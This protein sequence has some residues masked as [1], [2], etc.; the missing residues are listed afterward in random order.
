MAL[1]LR[2]VNFA[3]SCDKTDTLYEGVDIFIV[4]GKIEAIG[5]D[6]DVG[7]EQVIN[8]TDMICYPGLINTHH[9]L[10]QFF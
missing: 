1:L 6:L 7:A 5:I 10:Y 3:V 4:D 2:N 9:H 8:C